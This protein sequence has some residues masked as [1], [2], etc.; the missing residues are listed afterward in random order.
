M[1]S[2]CTLAMLL[3]ALALFGANLILGGYAVAQGRAPVAVED[4]EPP[5]IQ[6]FT[7]EPMPRTYDTGGQSQIITVTLS[8]YDMS[9]I[10][11]G[12]CGLNVMFI[13]P[14]EQPL[15]FRFCHG[16]EGEPNALI[17]DELFP[18]LALWQRRRVLA[19]DSEPGEWRID[20]VQLVDTAGNQAVRAYLDMLN[21]GFPV[22]FEVANTYDV[23]IPIVFSQ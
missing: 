7:I 4:K 6:T 8:V 14:S 20:Y 9:G 19:A 10:D 1:R 23:S 16:V 21:D 15:E 3:L 22:S 12:A 18:P 13:G 2:K 17:D 5:I 11:G